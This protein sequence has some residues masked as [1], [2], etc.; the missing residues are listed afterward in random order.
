MSARRF[1]VGGNWKLNGSKSANSELVNMLNAVNI[2]D[3][4]GIFPFYPSW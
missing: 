3:N 4:T 1:F 2:P